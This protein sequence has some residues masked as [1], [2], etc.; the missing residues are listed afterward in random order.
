MMRRAPNLDEVFRALAEPFDMALPSF[1]QHMALLEECGLVR[2][3][4]PGRI[5]ICTSWRQK[6]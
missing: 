2:S 4:K 1:V 6:P 5:R 3:N